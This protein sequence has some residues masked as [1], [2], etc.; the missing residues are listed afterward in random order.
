VVL[1]A[2]EER[3]ALE[4][5]SVAVDLDDRAPIHAAA[6]VQAVDLLE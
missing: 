6:H 1:D 4:P 3:P 2:R 5:R